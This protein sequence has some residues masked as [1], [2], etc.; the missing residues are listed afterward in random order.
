MVPRAFG[1]GLARLLQAANVFPANPAD[2]AA[3]GNGLWDVG[4]LLFQGCRRTSIGRARAGAHQN[5]TV[6]CAVEQRR[7]I[8]G[9]LN[10][11]ATRSACPRARGAS[12]SP[13]T[14]SCIT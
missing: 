10:P 12:R 6:Q 14:L 2:V 3:S 4:R 8:P 1:E 13:L 7:I 5:P 11:K 9:C